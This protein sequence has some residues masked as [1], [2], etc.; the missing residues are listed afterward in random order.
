MFRYADPDVCLACRHQIDRTEPACVMCGL[1]LV[2]EPAARVFEA[3]S[4]VDRSVAELIAPDP[5]ATA[6]SDD[7]QEI[8]YRRSSATP[9]AA[10][11]PTLSAASVPKILLGLG[12]LCLLVASVVFL[13]VA[14]AALGVGGRTGVLVGFTVAASLLMQWVSRRGLRAGAEA[15]AAVVLGLLVIDLGGAREAGWLGSIDEGWFLVLVGSALA[16]TGGLVARWARTTPAARALSAEAGAVVGVALTALAAG[17]VWGRTEAEA[18]LVA[19]LVCLGA[20]VTARRLDLRLVALGCVTEAIVAW[21][22]LVAAA[23]A[24]LWPPSVEHVWV[25]L[26]VWPTLVAAA[27]AGLVAATRSLPLWSRVTAASAALVV[28]GLAVTVVSF[29]ESATTVV[30][31][32]L[33]VIAVCGVAVVRLAPVWR[34]AAAVPSMM[35]ALPLAFSVVEIALEAVER[36]LP[37]GAWTTALADGVPGQVVPWTWPLLLP[38]GVIGVCTCVASVFRCA[39]E[40]PRPVVLPGA[41]VALAAAVLAPALYGV[42]LGFAVLALA[43]GAAV[44]G[45][46]ALVTGRVAVGATAA[47]TTV[48]AVVASLANEWATAIVL[49]MVLTGALVAERRPGTLVS[50]TGLVSAPV[51]AGGLLWTLGHLAGLPTVWLALPVLIVLGSAVVLRPVLD[52][53]VVSGLVAAVAVAVSVAG[54]GTTD[55]T[56]LAVYLTVGGVVATGS[57]LLNPSRRPLARLG[58]VFFTAAQWVRLDQLGVGTVEA[59]TLPLAL[60]LVVLGSVSLARGAASSVRTLGPGLGLAV[61]PTL[62]LVLADPVGLRALLLGLACVA[63]VAT[64]LLGRLAAPLAVGAAA[65]ALLVL[66]EGTLAQVL[67]QWALIGLVGVGLT[68]LGITW[69]QRLQELQRASAY[70]RGLR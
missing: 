70:V 16:A 55:Q 44:L 41:A 15:F 64:G 69:E 8:R 68:V 29:D 45:A 63:L 2:G 62:L 3:L 28:A 9:V 23:G 66:R 50:V 25:D 57:A 22:V 6:S 49:G 54:D 43:L 13:V 19:T 26:A 31:V 47:A 52:L 59:Y 37:S 39:S 48:L 36:I 40:D 21:L 4:Y 46:A 53:E 24:M 5:A 42:P 58:L 1:D 65:G 32:Q 56:W 20:V 67:P 12:A 30:L 34:W 38:A 51:A 35:A 11:R 33:G 7:R 27:L 14:W 61:L 17:D 18:A 10:P 60:V